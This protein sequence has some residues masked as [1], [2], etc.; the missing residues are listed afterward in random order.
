MRIN[1][2]HY[3]S[4]F[5]KLHINTDELYGISKS[6][7]KQCEK[8]LSKTKHVDVF[9]DSQG[10]TIKKKMTEIL[11]KIQSFSLFPLE[12]AVGITVIE[13]N[14][15]KVLKMFYKTTEE[16]KRSWRTLSNCSWLN[17]IESHTI[18]ALWLDNYFESKKRN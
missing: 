14:E 16:A 12:R 2:A 15:K 1:N 9:I 6:S 11:Q 3:F 17:N 18:I 10:I 5:G 13:N 4:A 7:L 8:L